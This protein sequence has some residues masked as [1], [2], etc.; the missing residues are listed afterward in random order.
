M[1]FNLNNFGVRA[2]IAL[3]SIIFLFIFIIPMLHRIINLGNIFGSIVSASV[4]IYIVFYSKF[5]AL[6]ENIKATQTGCILINFVNICIASALI[7]SVIITFFMVKTAN[8]T[9]ENN[10][11][12]LVVLG[13]KVKNGEP[14]LMLQRRLDTAY[15]YLNDNPDAKVIVSG[16]K[17]TDEII[18]EAECMTNYL[19]SKGISSDRIYMESAST[20]TNENLAFSKKLI[21]ENHLSPKITIVTDGFHQ[22]RAELIAKKQGYKDIKNLSASTA[23]WLL[24]TYYVR[25]LFGVTYQFT[26]GG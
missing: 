3:A 20:S 25:E 15:T 10:Y 14:S 21:D 26:I 12:T 1:I 2:F 8:D 23:L 5:T 13:C 22:L 17:G 7:I 11:T 18:S 16:G 6:I 9:P 19:L 4:L 24:P